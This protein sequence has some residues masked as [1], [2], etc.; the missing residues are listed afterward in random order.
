MNNRET[1]LPIVAA[2]L[3]F[4][5][6]TAQSQ[7]LMS[8]IKNHSNISTFANAL[9]DSGLDQKL[10]GAGPFTVFAPVNEQFEKEISGKN[11]G[12]TAV[13]NLIMNHIM[14]GYASERNMKIMSKATSLGGITL[15]MKTQG[16]QLKINNKEI[17]VMNIKANN[18]VLHIVKGVLK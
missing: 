5:P 12:S 13:K 3:L 9:E 11:P 18:G 14:T 2:I 1:I 17:V 10:N 7:K 8:V 4:L 16:D 15:V 6:A